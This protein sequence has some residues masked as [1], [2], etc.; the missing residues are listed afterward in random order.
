VGVCL[1]LVGLNFCGETNNVYYARVV[2]SRAFRRTVLITRIN[3]FF[4]CIF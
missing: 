3:F 4:D 2:V 1:S